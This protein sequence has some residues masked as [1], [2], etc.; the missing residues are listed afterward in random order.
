ML[1]TFKFLLRQKKKKLSTFN[2]SK[3]KLL[4]PV[5]I[6]IKNSSY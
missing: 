2:K 3:F 6:L 1:S 4:V 5:K